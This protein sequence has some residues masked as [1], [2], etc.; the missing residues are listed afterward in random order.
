MST[1][2]PSVPNPAAGGRPGSI[3]ICR[4]GPGRTGSRT[5]DEIPLDA[6]GPRIGFAYKTTDKQVIRGGYGIYYAGVTFGQGGRPT[7]G[8]D[9]N[10]TAP[11]LTNGR[12][13]AFHLDHGIPGKRDPLP[14]VH[15]SRLSRTGLRRSVI[16]R[17]D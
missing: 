11:N 16:R 17:M 2:D 12:E 1:F 4:Y 15:R 8:F 5:F 9:S 10:P 7:L 6:I 3:E 13:P 14:T